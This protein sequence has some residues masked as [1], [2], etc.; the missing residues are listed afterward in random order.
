MEAKKQN[1]I[2]NYGLIGGLISI[3]SFL[4]LYMG[5]ASLFVNPLAFIFYLVPITM[6]VLAC[7]A[8]KKQ[9]GGFLEFAEALKTSFGVMVIMALV[10]TIATYIV[11]NIIDPSFRESLTQVTI[12]KTQEMMKK[13]GVP[14]ADIDKK[15]QEL[16]TTNSFG[17]GK[18]LM[19][20]A[21]GCILWF[22]VALIISA[23]VKKKKPE[24]PG[25]VA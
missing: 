12:E 15:V 5:G 20:F 3:V 11:L 14:Q 23:I 13:F 19:Q 6:A 17:I 24:F 8:K 2:L 9:N 7:R 25:A 16:A 10:S 22:I 4:I 18:L 21:F 1:V